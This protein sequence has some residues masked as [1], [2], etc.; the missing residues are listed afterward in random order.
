MYKTEWLTIVAQI[1]MYNI[2]KYLLLK[3][4]LQEGIHPE[5]V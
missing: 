5:K 4:C 1:D 3:G 2:A